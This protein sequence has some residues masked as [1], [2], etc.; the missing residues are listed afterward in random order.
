MLFSPRFNRALSEASQ[1]EVLHKLIQQLV[2]KSGSRRIL[3]QKSGRETRREKNGC[4]ELEHWLLPSAGYKQ[5][6]GKIMLHMCM[7]A[8][9]PP[10]TDKEETTGH[11]PQFAWFLLPRLGEIRSSL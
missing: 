4:A 6:L 2:S 9:E 1:H 7:A 3:E 5:V 10:G 8:V 11:Q